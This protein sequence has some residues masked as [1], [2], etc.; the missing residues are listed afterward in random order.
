M[1]AHQVEVLDVSDP[2]T[3]SQ[4]WGI[5]IDA[6]AVEAEIIGFREIPPLHETLER[7]VAKPLRW[8]G[9]RNHTDGAVVAALGFTDEGGVVDIDRLFV[10]PG[11]LRNGHAGTLLAALGTS[12]EITVSAAL[13][14][15]PAI[16]LYEAHGF[17]RCAEEE[18]VPG[19]IIVHF[20]REAA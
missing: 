8:L 3:A 11:S 17:V 1:S 15:E 5:Q 7:M 2:S 20:R 10:A 19:L 6:Y 9:I 12:R 4:V 16:R 13:A 18:I 14:N